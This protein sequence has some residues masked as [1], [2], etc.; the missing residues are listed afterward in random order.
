MNI[1]PNLLGNS[2]IKE[3]C[4]GDILQRKN[5]HAYI[6][7]GPVGSGKH[8]AALEIAKAI[9]CERKGDSLPCGK[10]LSCRKADEGFNSCIQYINSDGK[11]TI[12]VDTIRRAIATVDY[13]PDDGDFSIYIIE[14]AEKMNTQAQNALLLTLEE[15]PSHVVFLLL[16]SDSHAL[17]ETVRS[18][19]L[20]LKTEALS[21]AAILSELSRRYGS[22]EKVKNAASAA[23]TLG[24][25][26]EIMESSDNT[27]AEVRRLA[28]EI[29]NVLKRGDSCEAMIL[30]RDMK[31]D[32]QTTGEILEWASLALRDM[33]CDRCGGDN[34]VFFTSRE[35][36]NRE[37]AGATLPHLKRMYDECVRAADHIK[38]KN[39]SAATVLCSLAAGCTIK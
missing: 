31:Y 20:T 23:A 27:R 16:C 18:R 35:D 30:L 28:G 38:N 33:I 39:A 29:A 3:L 21:P 10:C 7:D 5:S 22:S 15:P 37:A 19:A 8:T 14:E 13:L 25:A 26:I 9:L 2:A 12:T 24:D 11:A 1:F 34:F 32:R 4:G 36:A 6:I 17:L